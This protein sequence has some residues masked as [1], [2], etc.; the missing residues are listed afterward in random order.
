MG[1]AHLGGGTPPSEGGVPP[2]RWAAVGRLPTPSHRPVGDNCNYNV[3]SNNNDDDYHHHNYNHNNYNDHD[4]YHHYNYYHNNYNA[5]SNN[6]YHNYHYNY[7]YY[8]NNNYNN[9]SPTNSTWRRYFLF[10]RPM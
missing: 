5:A 8:H 3:A 7:Y 10:L 6:D 2:G 1:S 9:T 4:D